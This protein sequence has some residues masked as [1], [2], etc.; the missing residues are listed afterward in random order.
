[1]IY[2]VARTHSLLLVMLDMLLGSVSRKNDSKQGK[3]E[4]SLVM[5]NFVCDTNILNTKSKFCT[6]IDFIMVVIFFSTNE[7]HFGSDLHH[8][9]DELIIVVMNFVC[10]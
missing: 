8:G 9:H 1:M 5:I 10:T 4:E 3:A 6:T 2:F 7:H